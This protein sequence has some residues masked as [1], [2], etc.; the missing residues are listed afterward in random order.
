VGETRSLLPGEQRGS[1]WTIR[2]QDRGGSGSPWAAARRRRG[3]QSD[4]VRDR[5]H[6]RAVHAIAPAPHDAGLRKCEAANVL[7]PERH[8][9]LA[10]QRAISTRR[11]PRRLDRAASPSWSEPG[12]FVVSSRFV[13]VS[14]PGEESDRMTHR[15]YRHPC[16]R[17]RPRPRGCPQSHR[18]EVPVMTGLAGDTMTSA[19]ALDCVASNTTG[20][21][22][23]SLKDLRSPA[24]PAVLARSATPYNTV[25]AISSWTSKAQTGRC[26]RCP[27]SKGENDDRTRRLASIWR[28]G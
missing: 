24:R 16:A 7:Q 12:G 28:R 2:R 20:G 11:R 17:P 13:T 21:P 23:N 4:P 27:H 14:Q 18:P 22:R 10:V 8:V 25:P 5:R 15:A 3:V 26:Y 1:R 9:P 6:R 19:T